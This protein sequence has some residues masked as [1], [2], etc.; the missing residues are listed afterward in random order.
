M[1]LLI[2]RPKNESELMEKLLHYS[3]DTKWIKDNYLRLF[4]QH[5]M[6]YV[7]VKNQKVVYIA[8]SMEEIVSKIVNDGKIP[9]NFAI[10]YLTDEVCNF[11]F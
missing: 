9:G 8:D 4:E 11:L 10:D 3:R 6:K 2:N 5:P 1:P 7:A